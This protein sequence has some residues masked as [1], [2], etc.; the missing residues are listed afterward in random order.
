MR[1]PQPTIDPAEVRQQL[2]GYLKDWQRLLMGH[3][4]QAQQVLRRLIIGRLTF[5]PHADGYYA[6]SEKDTVEPVL[7]GIVRKL[8]SP[9]GTAEGWQLVVKGFSDLAA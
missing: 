6:F 9:T 7:W 2:Q 8:A 5:T 3:V 4:G 1:A